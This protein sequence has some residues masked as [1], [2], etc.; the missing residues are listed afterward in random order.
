MI[1]EPKSLAHSSAKVLEFE[2]VLEML[3]GYA[4]SEPGRARV[5]GLLPATEADW[6]RQQH[7]LSTEIGDFLRSGA[8]FEFAGLPES[9]A[10]LERSRI[11]GV[12]L[13]ITEIRD[14][15]AI[16]DR[17]AAWCQIAFNPPSALR[18]G[19]PAVAELSQGFADFA[20]L[21][22]FFR[23]K[24]AS[25]GTLDDRASP[26]LAR[27][28]RE[29]EKQKRHI[30]ESLRGYLR[31]LAEGGAVQDEVVTIRGERFVIPVK[32]EH[33]RRVSG[34][35]HGASSSGQTVFVEPMETIEQNNE[36]VRLLEEELAEVQRILR[37][38]TARFG[39]RA[40]EIAIASEILAELE[41]QFAKAR[42]AQDYGCVAP[43]ILEGQ[44][45]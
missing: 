23:N 8:R 14:V 32:I 13:A 42:F 36:L 31:R 2:G 15:L 10:A 17:A 37:E 20:A 33:K 3:R 4:R 30:Q 16:A 18:E 45:G 21:L 9:G 29:I 34:V 39:E 12:A 27:L 35:V 1:R 5:G 19:W 11:E 41:L 40:E 24:I 26:E 28:R 44:Q 43:K 25:D 7:Q 6:I 22:G 38:M